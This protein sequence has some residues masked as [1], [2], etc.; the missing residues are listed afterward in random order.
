MAIGALLE[1]L[2]PIP[3]WSHT[4]TFTI[5]DLCVSSGAPACTGQ[6]SGPPGFG[7]EAV[8]GVEGPREGAGASRV[9]S[10]TTQYPSSAAPIGG[11]DAASIGVETWDWGSSHLTTVPTPSPGAPGPWGSVPGA[12]T[13]RIHG[14]GSGTGRKHRHLHLQS[15]ATARASGLHPTGGW[16]AG[17]R[18][19]PQRQG[20]RPPASSPRPAAHCRLPSTSSLP[21]LGSPGHR[22]Q[23]G[24]QEGSDPS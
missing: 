20:H 17:S 11:K 18:C 19:V 9:L 16:E 8:W 10:Q 4:W 7:G 1:G 12:S 3:S 13:P 14:G 21:G 24:H 15:T 22:G 5:K 2:P 6:H 23:G